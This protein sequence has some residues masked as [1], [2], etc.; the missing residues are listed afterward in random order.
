MDNEADISGTAPAGD[1]RERRWRLAHRRRGRDIDQRFP[2]R[3]KRLSAALDALYGD[4]DG[5]THRRASD[6]AGSAAR[7]RGSAQWMGDIRSIL[8]RAG[9]PGVQKDAFERLKL[10]QMLME[11]EFLERVEAD[12][13]LVADLISLRSVM[14][15]KTKDTAPHVIAESSPS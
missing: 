9:R 13:N 11:P 2:T 7:H 14:P 5:D 1:G 12:V 15:A 3:D 6:A 4:G 8:S 10:K